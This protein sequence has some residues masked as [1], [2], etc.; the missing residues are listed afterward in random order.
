[1]KGEKKE[2]LT[3]QSH[4]TPLFLRR[5]EKGRT[6]DETAAGAEGK[7]EKEGGREKRRRQ[8]TTE[9][10]GKTINRFLSSHPVEEREVSIGFRGKG[11][12]EDKTGG[13]YF[14]L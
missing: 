6:H 7:E 8:T 11:K 4:S 12:G 5:A 2:P 9:E 13:I 1:V 3:P 10:E 14:F